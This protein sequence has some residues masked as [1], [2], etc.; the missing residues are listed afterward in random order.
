MNLILLGPPGAGKGTQAKLLEGKFGLKQLSSGDMLRSAVSSETA[1]GQRAKSFMDRGALV[2]DDLVVDV[3]FEHLAGFRDKKGYI[4]DG[5]PRTVDQAEA[6]DAWLA[7]RNSGIDRVIVIQVRDDR[8]VERIVGRYTCAKCGEGYH[9][10]FKAPAIYG[11][12]D[13]C[14]NHEFKRRVDDTPATVA[15]RIKTYHDQT[16]PLI[17]YYETRGKVAI[18]DGEAPIEAVSREIDEVFS[19]NAAG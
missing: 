17:A 18:V 4:L 10:S 19:T 11:V 6:L 2:P 12:C 13:Q 1:V 15:T 5:F 9:D 8:L 7:S 14:G 16:A 3:V